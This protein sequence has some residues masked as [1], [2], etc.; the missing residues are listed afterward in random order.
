MILIDNNIFKDAASFA[1][2]SANQ[3]ILRSPHRIRLGILDF[4]CAVLLLLLA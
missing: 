3:R 1:V 4:D 2:Y